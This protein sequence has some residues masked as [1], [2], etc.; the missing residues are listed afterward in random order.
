M[1]CHAPVEGSCKMDCLS[2]G[3][4]ICDALFIQDE[5]QKI[6]RLIDEI[7]FCLHLACILKACHDKQDGFLQGI[8]RLIQTRSWNHILTRPDV[9]SVRTG[10]L[11][12]EHLLEGVCAFITFGQWLKIPTVTDCLE[13]GGMIMCIGDHCAFLDIGGNHHG[14]DAHPQAVESKALLAQRR[15]QVGW[16]CRRGWD[17]IITAAM[18]IEGD[19]EQRP[20]PTFAVSYSL[21]YAMISNSPASK[22]EVSNI[23]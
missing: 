13:Y 12:T 7:P 22:L 1:L 21:I 18:F 9:N 23:S 4:D 16:N 6:L 20:V 17:V 8:D 19:D 11:Q 14:G 10:D 15:F 5:L 2:N 3:L